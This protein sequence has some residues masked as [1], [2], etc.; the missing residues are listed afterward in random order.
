MSSPLSAAEPAGSPNG[1]P[2][3][4][5]LRRSGVRRATDVGTRVDCR[6]RTYGICGPEPAYWLGVKNGRKPQY[7]VFIPGCRIATQQ[8]KFQ[9]EE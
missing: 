4:S 6:N 7:S 5:A 8:V 3:H 2:G 9:A 1:S